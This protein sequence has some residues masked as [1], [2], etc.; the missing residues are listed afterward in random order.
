MNLKL[1]RKIYLNSKLIGIRWFYFIGIYLLGLFYIYSDNK[2]LEL[3]VEGISLLLSIFLAIN[4]L[5][6]LFLIRYKGNI[7]SLRLDFFGFTQIFTEILLFSFLAYASAAADSSLFALYFLPIAGAALLYGAFG[8]VIAG[9]VSVFMYDSAVLMH[10]NSVQAARIE[11]FA[12][13]LTINAFFMVFAVFIGYM[14][15]A[16]YN[17]EEGLSTQKDMLEKE[18]NAKEKEVKEMDKV[19]KMLVRRDMDLREMNLELDGKIEELEK[20]EKAQNEALEELKMA[21]SNLEE[22]KYKTDAIID[23]FSDPIIVLNKKNRIR[24]MNPS[25]RE[26]LGMKESTAGKIISSKNNFSIDNFSKYITRKFS[27]KNI[28]EKDSDLHLQEI[29]I[30]YQGMDI[31]YK[32][33][34]KK[35]IGENKEFLGTMKI[36]YDITRE[37]MIDSLK[38][39]FISIAAHQLRTPL[40]AIKWAI[41]MVLDGDAG[42]LNLEQ[43]NI[44]EK[45]YKSNE[46]IIVLINDMLNVSKLEEG[47]LGFS[48]AKSDIIGI[49]K[50]TAGNLQNKINENKQTLSINIVNKIPLVFIDASKIML[51]VQNLIENAVKYTPINGKISIDLKR[52][53]EYVIFKV[54]D[55]GVGIPENCK[56]ELFSK[57][58]RADNVIRMQTEGSGLGLFIAGNVI[59][60]HFG[61]IT[62]NSREGVGTEFIVKLPID[63]RKTKVLNG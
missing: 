53:G 56:N 49:I 14:I 21:R 32:V 46:R 34:T 11:D 9:I 47:K 30:Q 10:L 54:K 15:D 60:K 16:F 13:M 41:R 19:A 55:N 7:G 35:I 43:A 62:C 52:E 58:F 39:E 5:F 37:K 45:G 23:N 25:A 31:Y 26:I 3:N 20:L 38:S 22:E 24:L 61:T 12:G 63:H 6:K 2:V 40:S 29:K 28:G 36:F 33:I 48:Y 27:V 1:E 8:S 50:E 51:A 57:F 42:K 17:R 59:K 44:L 4:L 18:K